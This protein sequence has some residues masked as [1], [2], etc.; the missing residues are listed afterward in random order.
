[1]KKKSKKKKVK[2]SI[3][4]K[5]GGNQYAKIEDIG[6]PLNGPINLHFFWGNAYT[7]FK[8]KPYRP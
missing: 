1:M 6:T 3:K 4:K 7:Y 2:L 5:Y 8:E